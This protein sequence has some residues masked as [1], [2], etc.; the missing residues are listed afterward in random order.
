VVDKDCGSAHGEVCVEVKN[1]WKIFGDDAQ[2]VL[3]SDLKNAGKEE[4]LEKA[5]AV[6]AV[7]DVSFKIRRGEF[8]VI[9]GLSGSGKSTLI[10][11]L[12]RLTEPV[13]GNIIINGKDI[14]SF[15]DKELVRLR[16]HTTS[17]V[18]QQFGLLPH[19][20][21]LENVAY[22]L[23]VRGEDKGKRLQRAQEATETVGLKGWE[24]SMPSTLSGG[25]QQ[26]VGIARALAT[27]P[28]ILLMDEPFSGL[29]PLIRRQMQDELIELQEKVQKT[30][31][32]VTH[33]LNE[34]LKMGCRIA[35]MRD[36]DIIQIGTPEE[37]VTTPADS[38]V[39]DF[40][41]DASAAKVL[42]AEYIMDQPGVLL[43]DWQGPKAALQ[44]M[45]DDDVDSAFIV[46]RR[47][48]LLGC[49][50]TIH[51]AKAIGSKDAVLTDFMEKAT[52]C[53][54]DTI[55]EELFPIAAECDYPI[56]VVDEE[57]KLLG[58]IQTSAILLSM[59][60]NVSQED[61]GSKQ[62]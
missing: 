18:F 59:S 36:G 34:A 10:R 20:T 61:K 53:K 48:D 16:R 43:Y 55:I 22:G 2:G 58:E 32:F 25:M 60:Q 8:F 49:V 33:D 47:R 1:L 57:N 50:S 41:Q 40:V 44:L 62:G 46:N 9:M 26:R 54:P 14:C 13:A 4:V 45:K 19:K 52:T 17:M 38:Y 15:D 27:E 24:N 42:T 11:L 35:I 56:A 3:N 6:I 39:S 30:I 37:V 28:E 29:D 23:K 31:I 51:L 21:V 12:L 7:R 5:G